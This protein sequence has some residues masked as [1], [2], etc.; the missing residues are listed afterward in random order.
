[1]LVINKLDLLPYVD[2][3][4]ARV[5]GQALAVNP[6]LR[7]FSLSCR[8]GEGLQ[9]WCDWLLQVV[10][11]RKLEGGPGCRCGESSAHPRGHAS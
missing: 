8:S 2:Y 10:H 3:D 7:L 4:L 5:R 11:P 1:V 9:A 6:E